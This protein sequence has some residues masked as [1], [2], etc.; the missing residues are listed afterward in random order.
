VTLATTPDP[1]AAQAFAGCLR[2]AA[3][4]GTGAAPATA[5]APTPSPAPPSRAM[6]ASTTPAAA[7]RTGGPWD[8]LQ[9]ADA[10]SIHR[11]DGPIGVSV[12]SLRGAGLVI[13]IH[14]RGAFEGGRRYGLRFAGA[15][16]AAWT[17]PVSAV[18]ANTLVWA[19]P[20]DGLGHRRVADLLR[21]GMVS[22]AELEDLPPTRLPPA[23][24][25]ADDFFRCG[26]GAFGPPPSPPPP[27]SR[28]PQREA[29]PAASLAAE[30]D[31]I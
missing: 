11:L 13:T 31:R 29:G 23:G 14:G 19:V 2:T 12:A 9:R 28:A 20:A 1:A 17:L 4:S 27:P 3:G 16:G 10:C 30:S 5:S 25:A 26:E 22:V 7:L 24:S 6:V 18:N 15:D 21:G 8:V